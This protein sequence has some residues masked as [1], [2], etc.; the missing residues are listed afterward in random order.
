MPLAA[1]FH[2]LIVEQNILTKPTEK[3]AEYFAY[4]PHVFKVALVI[5]HLFR[6][7]AMAGFMMILPFSMPASAAICGAGSLF[8]RL[9][10]ESN[11]AYK[12]ALPALGGATAFMIGKGA[13]ISLISG[14]AFTSL[15]AFGAACVALIPLGVYIAY[16]ILTVSYDVD[17]RPC[18]FCPN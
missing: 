4:H 18:P 2:T 6:A 5:N 15:A 13:L 3:I 14:V 16:V 1:K 17:N 9:T 7:A 11:C 10:V 8:Y 12:F